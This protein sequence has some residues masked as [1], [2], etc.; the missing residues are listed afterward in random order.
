MRAT[1]YNLHIQTFTELLLHSWDPENPF[2]LS[3]LVYTNYVHSVR[4][5]HFLLSI[6]RAE[7]LMQNARVLCQSMLELEHNS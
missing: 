1:R 5:H 7:R 4:Q 3:A 2:R 6:S